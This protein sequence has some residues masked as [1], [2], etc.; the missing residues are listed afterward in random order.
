[1]NALRFMAQAPLRTVRPL[2]LRDIYAN[3]DKELARLR[4]QGY[5][6]QLA[7]GTYLVKPDTVPTGQNWTP[8]LEV[9]AMAYATAAHHPDAPVLYGISAARHWHAIPRAVGVAIVAVP[10][11]HRPVVLHTGGRIEFTVRSL[12]LL[13]TQPVDTV[14]GVMRVTTPEQTLVDLV[15]WPQLGGM[16]DQ[17]AQAAREII[18]Q[19]DAR[20]L[21]RLLERQ[22][23]TVARKVQTVLKD[24]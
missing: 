14:V 20:Q 15:A 21:Q 6:V 10:R 5:L 16:P 4:D 9:A 8:P 13:D 12:D 3:P 18:P 22:P 19:V 1:M 17:V 7:R 23:A 11:P 2:M 24:C